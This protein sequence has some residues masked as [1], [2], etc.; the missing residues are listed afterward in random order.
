[1]G[2]TFSNAPVAVVINALIAWWFSKVGIFLVGAVRA[3]V[4]KARLS[5][6]K[7]SRVLDAEMWQHLSKALA[8]ELLLAYHWVQLTTSVACVCVVLCRVYG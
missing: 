8:H 2:H 4:A 3:A 7:H 1:L 5:L 6:L